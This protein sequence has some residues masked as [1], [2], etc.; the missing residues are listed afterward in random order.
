MN[1]LFLGADAKTDQRAH[2][3]SPPTKFPPNA[4]E[5]RER[6]FEKFYRVPRLADADVPGTGVGL[7]LVREIAEL[8]SGRVTVESEPGVGS[9][10]TLH[11]PFAAY[12]E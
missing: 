12:E 6:I 9:S 4:A 2:R 5:A 8:H 10:F 7:A 11:L 3:P 1:Q